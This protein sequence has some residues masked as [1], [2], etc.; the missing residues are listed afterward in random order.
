MS[1][2]GR[3]KPGDKVAIILTLLGVIAFAGLA[4]WFAMARV[5]ASP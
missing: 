2:W 3:L 4:W 1:W 5:S